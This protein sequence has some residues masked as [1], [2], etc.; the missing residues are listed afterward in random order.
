MKTLDIRTLTP[1][2]RNAVRVGAVSDMK[3]GKFT[4]TEVARMYGTT[5]ISINKWVK[6]SRRKNGLQEKSRGRPVGT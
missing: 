4:I 2:A 3:S 6:L 1:S 5:T